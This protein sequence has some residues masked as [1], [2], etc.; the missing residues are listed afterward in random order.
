MKLRCQV[1][2][3]TIGNMGE[4]DIQKSFLGLKENEIWRTGTN[5][6]LMELFRHPEITV[7]AR[8]QRLRWLGHIVKMEKGRVTKIVVGRI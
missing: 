3:T 8:I 1:R 2:T 6:E 4:K 5:N 7:I